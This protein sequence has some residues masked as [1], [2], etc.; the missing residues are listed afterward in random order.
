MKSWQKVG[1]TVVTD[2]EQTL[3][4]LQGA[5]SPAGYARLYVQKAAR[6]VI[7]AQVGTQTVT[8]FDG[9]VTPG[10]GKV[11]PFEVRV[12]RHPDIDAKAVPPDP[13]IAAAEAAR[14]AA[15]G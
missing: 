1:E 4:D 14:I 10:A 3:A 11:S 7:A 5:I 12:R 6:V 9:Q 2:A 8:L 15:E 13:A